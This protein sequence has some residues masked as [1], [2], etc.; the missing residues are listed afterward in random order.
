MTSLWLVIFDCVWIGHLAM[1]KGRMWRDK[2]REKI[3]RRRDWDCLHRLVL[4]CLSLSLFTWWKREWE[5]EQ[6]WCAVFSFSQ[7]V[8]LLSVFHGCI[9]LSIR[10][11][12][13]AEKKEKK[14]LFAP[15]LIFLFSLY[16]CFLFR[17]WTSWLM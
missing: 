16:P 6:E 7:F 9:L 4:S 2:R 3:G 8:I 1:E 11:R 17:T 12:K 5:R 13:G 10:T 14:F 15:S